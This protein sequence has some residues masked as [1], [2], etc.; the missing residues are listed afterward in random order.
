VAPLIPPGKGIIALMIALA[1]A[2]CACASFG[3]YSPN[4]DSVVDG[5]TVSVDIK[6]GPNM[7]GLK[8]SLDG[9]DVTS[10]RA[11]Q[12]SP[13][14]PEAFETYLGIAMQHFFAQR[15]Q[16]AK[17]WADRALSEKPDFIPALI[18]KAASMA[19]AG[20]PAEEIH[21]VVQNIFT[22]RPISIAGTRQ[23]MR[24]FREADVEVFVTGLRK[25]GIPEE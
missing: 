14:D 17:S 5:S 24:S 8:V 19:A 6:G 25:A 9:T 12:I 18:A 21:D 11:M 23:R 15:F 16:E 2:L 7:S 4:R 3:I 10:M 20:F 1:P 13:L 22:V